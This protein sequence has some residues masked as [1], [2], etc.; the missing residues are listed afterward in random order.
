MFATFRRRP[1][2]ALYD[3]MA[4][5]WHGA[6]QKLGYPAAYRAL[7]SAHPF[8]ARRVLDV[9]S[10]TGHF[11]LAWVERAGIPDALTLL[12]PSSAMLTDA[13]DRLAAAGVSAQFLDDGVGTDAISPGSADA[14]LCAH[15]IEHLD[16]PQAA[17]A[18]MLSRL[19]PGGRLFL[20]ASQPHWCTALVR[21]RYGHR[22]YRPEQVEAMLDA[23]GFTRV[24]S[25]P[26]AAGPPS[27]MSHGYVAD[28]PA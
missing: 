14:I 18:W 27:R 25:M 23:A 22:A 28:R 26:F 7:I 4:L 2:A 12:D 13:A 16:D 11:A 19:R 5:G 9:G 20:A 10:G 15:V 8:G 21:M 1:L 17:L 3:R 24:A 6:V